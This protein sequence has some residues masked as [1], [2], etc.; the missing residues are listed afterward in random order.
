MSPP[1][2]NKKPKSKGNRKKLT[3]TPTRQLLKAES[4]LSEQVRDGLDAVIRA[5]IDC[6]DASIRGDFSDSLNLDDATREGREN[7]NR[8]DYLL[9]HSATGKV[10][11]LE[12]HTAREDQISTIIAKKTAALLHIRDEVRTGKA[13]AR[14]I[15][16]ASG[17]VRFTQIDKAIRRLDQA[18][19]Q[20]A[21]SR[22]LAKHLP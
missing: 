3:V 1:K 15:W 13:V 16:V 22:L 19:I 10:V 4:V 8:W 17:N 7:E 5:E 9:G 18:G 14:W 12:P 21:G 20:F 2:L 6:I 11:A